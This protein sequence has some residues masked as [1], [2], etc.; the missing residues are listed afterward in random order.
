[1]VRDRVEE[2]RHDVHT[3]NSAQ[4]GRRRKFLRKK[5]TKSRYRL[6]V[7]LTAAFQVFSLYPQ[8][9]R[10]LSVGGVEP[11]FARRAK[12]ILNGQNDLTPIRS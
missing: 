8:T 10:P 2:F 12:S 9:F 3:G 1:M 5:L 7:R 4:S 11:K 6:T